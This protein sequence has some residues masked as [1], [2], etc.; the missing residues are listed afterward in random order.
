MFIFLNTQTC[1]RLHHSWELLLVKFLRLKK[2]KTK[3]KKSVHLGSRLN[4]ILEE[5]EHLAEG[6]VGKVG[7]NRAQEGHAKWF[8]ASLK[9]IKRV[10]ENSPSLSLGSP[11]F[12]E[13]PAEKDFLMRTHLCTRCMDLFSMALSPRTTG[14]YTPVSPALPYAAWGRNHVGYH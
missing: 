7:K 10:T 4:K 3:E 14:M 6:K 8:N 11:S 12:Q 9:V 5:L 2:E 1:Q 13:L